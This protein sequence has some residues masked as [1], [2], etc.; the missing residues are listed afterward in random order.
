MPR[1]K[2]GICFWGFVSGLISSRELVSSRWFS[3]W[4]GFVKDSKSFMIWMFSTLWGLSKGSEY[5]KVLIFLELSLSLKVVF[6]S[7]RWILS[8]GLRVLISS[9][10]FTYFGKSFNS[11][12]VS[13]SIIVLK[14]K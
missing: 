10:I 1:T 14:F 11:S 4:N 2:F 12:L 5:V 9:D 7:S 13:W 8:L 6:M 3:S